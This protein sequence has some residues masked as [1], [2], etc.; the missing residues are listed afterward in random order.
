MTG[1]VVLLSGMGSR[2][3]DD[4]NRR[5]SYD[6]SEDAGT[7]AREFGPGPYDLTFD[8]VVLGPLDGAKGFQRALEG[9]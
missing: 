7:S 2:Q 8:T 3:D 5:A 9:G 4:R 1:S 6:L